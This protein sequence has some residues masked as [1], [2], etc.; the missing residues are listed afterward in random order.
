MFCWGD[1]LRQHR[2]K[3]RRTADAHRRPNS[4]VLKGKMFVRN[5]ASGPDPHDCHKSTVQ[6]Y[7]FW[8]FCRLGRERAERVHDARLHLGGDAW[9]A[10]LPEKKWLKR[11]STGW[12]RIDHLGVG[13]VSDVGSDRSSK[14]AGFEADVRGETNSVRLAR[15]LLY[16]QVVMEVNGPHFHRHL[17]AGASSARG[18]RFFIRCSRS[19]PDPVCRARP[20]SAA[21]LPLVAQSASCLVPTS[22]APQV[23]RSACRAS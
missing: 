13:A 15:P 5:A 18:R 9:V 16:S 20:P 1:P 11:R 4:R 12:L 10:V 14:T 23:A 2:R 7:S 21:W 19:S 8:A 22:L 17:V 6:A 3:D